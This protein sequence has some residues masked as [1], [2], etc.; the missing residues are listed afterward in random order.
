MKKL[1]VCTALRNELKRWSVHKWNK[2]DQWS[3]AYAY[4]T[5]NDVLFTWVTCEKGYYGYQ[6]IGQYPL[7]YQL[8]SDDV[9]RGINRIMT[10]KTISHIVD[11]DADIFREISKGMRRDFVIKLGNTMV[12]GVYLKRMLK[13]MPNPTITVSDNTRAPVIVTEYGVRGVL[14]P[15]WK[16]PENLEIVVE[17]PAAY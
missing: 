10:D 11:F 16:K 8:H 6:A 7:P 14:M 15:L 13:V 1:S 12:N 4:R 9:D 3:K 17:F 2:Y 5:E